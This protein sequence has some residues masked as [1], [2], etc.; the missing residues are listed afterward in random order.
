MP[1]NDVWFFGLFQRFALVARLTA[2]FIFT[3][4]S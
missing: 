2:A 3:V 1:F 4:L